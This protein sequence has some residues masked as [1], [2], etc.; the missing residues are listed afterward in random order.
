MRSRSHLPTVG[1]GARA[2]EVVRREMSPS[3]PLSHP[4][5]AVYFHGRSSM[6]RGR[7]VLFSFLAL[8][9][10]APLRAQTVIDPALRV[11]IVVQGLSAPTAMTFLGT[12]GEFL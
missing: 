6:N 3:F 1:C 10:I 4:P 2:A 12:G 5:G 11:E 7:V 8:S 9:G